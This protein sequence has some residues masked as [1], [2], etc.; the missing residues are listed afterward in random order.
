MLMIIIL[1][2]LIVLLVLRVP[3]AWAILIPCIVYIIATPGMGIELIAQRFVAGLNSY[4]LLAIPFFVM[5]GFAANT[6]GITSRVFDLAQAAFAPVR[7]AL[8]YVNVATGFVFSWMSGSALA[9]AAGL[10]AMQVPAMRKRG[11]DPKF[12]VGLTGAASILGGVMP[13]SI[14][15]IIFAATAGVS[16]GAV[17]LA[18]IVPGTLMA[19]FLCVNVYL[20]A[21]KRPELR[22]GNFDLKAVLRYAYRTLPVA[23]APIVI[24]GGIFGGFFSPTEAGAVGTAYILLLAVLYREWRWSKFLT[25]LKDSARTTANIGLIIGAA[26]LLSWILAREGVPQMV[27]GAL[28]S[29]TSNPIVFMILV[30]LLLLLVGMF[31]EA[32]SA[33]ILVVPTLLP[34]A[35]A[36]GID[37]VH[38]GIV[39]VINLMIGLLTPPVGMMIFVLSEVTKMSFMNVVRGFLR[40]YFPLLLVL[41]ITTTIALV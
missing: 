9:D 15:S 31:L 7:G 26:G 35:V 30:N 4:P 2:A 37:P 40:F 27:S 25:V 6:F 41:A 32:T 16:V 38:F 23:G 8:G 12:S 33:I 19:A 36:F 24:L 3:V 13:P 28:Q 14:P 5:L 29:I 22:H 17:F 11:Y 20:Y 21:R 39:V 1:A 10:G 34:A 18:G